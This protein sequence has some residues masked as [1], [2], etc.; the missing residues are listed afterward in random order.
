MCDFIFSEEAQVLGNK[1]RRKNVPV[2]PRSPWK[3]SYMRQHQI[4]Q[5]WRHGAIRIPKVN[6]LM[7]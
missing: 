3:S 4:E 6:C 2:S 5:N 1:L 7:N